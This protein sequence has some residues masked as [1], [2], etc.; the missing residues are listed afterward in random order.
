MLNQNGGSKTE[1]AVKALLVFLISLF[2]FS[3][4]TYVGKQVSD[5]EYRTSHLESQDSPHRT[6]ASVPESTKVEPESTLSDED[7]ASL[8]KEFIDSEKQK[9]QKPEHKDHE[10]SDQKPTK[11]EMDTDISEFKKSVEFKGNPVDQKIAQMDELKEMKKTQKTKTASKASAAAM[12]V[13][14][15]KA[16]SEGPK[17]RRPTSV[18]PK[19]ASSVVGKYTIQIA[20]YSTKKEALKHASQLKEK[21]YNAFFVPAKVK[22]TVWYRVS[23]GVFASQKSAMNFQKELKTQ[24]RI[25]A[26][27]ITR[28]T[29]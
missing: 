20:S 29:K 17:T 13:A 8:S 6:S 3:V 1:V 27:I 24:A 15:N 25:P 11:M 23:V 18:L 26:S 21:G 10:S 5:S 7:I 22:G 19:V 4:G 9:M 12:N 2:S 14:E 16:P 28:I